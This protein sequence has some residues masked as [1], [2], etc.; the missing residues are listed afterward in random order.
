M[1]T[2]RALLVGIGDYLDNLPLALDAPARDMAEMDELLREAARQ[3]GPDVRLDIETLT[4][5]EATSK[6][7]P[8][9]ASISGRRGRATPGRPAA[10]RLWP[11]RPELPD[12]EANHQM[13]TLLLHDSRTADGRDLYDKELRALIHEAVGDSGAVHF[14]V[15]ADCCHASGITK[16]LGSMAKTRSAPAF[17]RDGSLPLAS[18]VG[19]SPDWEK[20]KFPTAP[21]VTL[22]ACGPTE[23]AKELPMDDGGLPRGAFTHSLA[24]LLREKGGFN[25]SYRDLME[26]ASIA[27]RTV[28]DRQIPQLG[29]AGGAGNLEKTFLDA[30]LAQPTEYAV[31]KKGGE[32][33]VRAGSWHGMRPPEGGKRTVLTL[34]NTSPEREIWLSHVR[35]TESV[36][37]GLT[38][39]DIPLIPLAAVL[40]ELPTAEVAV[41]FSPGFLSKQERPALEKALAE[42]KGKNFRFAA[43]PAS[44]DFWMNADDGGRFF[45]EKKD[46]SPWP[47]VRHRGAADFVKQVEAIAKWT[48]VRNTAEPTAGS[49][50]ADSDFSIKL[51][52]LETARLLDP[53]LLNADPLLSD[54]TDFVEITDAAA[55]VL[56]MKN[57]LGEES[58]PFIKCRVEAVGRPLWMGALWLNPRF[59]ITDEF[60]QAELFPKGRGRWLG[61]W[62]W[63][64]FKQDVFAVPVNLPDALREVLLAEGVGEAIFWLKIFFS[65]RPF[66]L[67]Q[68][69]QE[70]LP[71]ETDSTRKD[72]EKE[73]DP[74]QAND[75]AWTVRTFPVRLSIG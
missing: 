56:S 67:G 64:A 29:H 30:F 32:W 52:R 62:N 5:D 21:H 55:T 12:D 17:N 61:G 9:S 38:D 13:E 71:L 19:Y 54:E 33:V 18:L 14:A 72:I 24:R 35:P 25:R 16:G 73:E 49:R 74:K 45:L 11:A 8:P 26:L 39:D 50:L 27:V 63:T 44:A 75:F 23:E 2:V 68:L 15:V 58:L 28:V 20:G 10:P 43:S 6:W 37:E 41:A 3:A 40:K 36:A 1:K 4:D 57:K 60:M 59:G 48:I 46:G 69:C 70:S 65:T 66:S 7:S 42:A 31:A 34:K 22:A 47:F 51:Y 53:D